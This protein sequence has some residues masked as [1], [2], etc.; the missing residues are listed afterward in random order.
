MIDQIM[1]TLK[2]AREFPDLAP[3]VVEGPRCGCTGDFFLS[4]LDE[5]R[6]GEVTLVVVTRRCGVCGYF[7]WYKFPGTLDERTIWRLFELLNGGKDG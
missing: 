7:P 3:Y 2:V 1:L 4:D 5:K 6:K